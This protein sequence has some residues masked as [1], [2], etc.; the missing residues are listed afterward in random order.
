MIA[1]SDR[2]WRHKNK[3]EMAGVFDRIRS[4]G[5]LMS[6][7][8]GDDQPIKI[9]GPVNW[10]PNK[11]ALYHLF[12]EGKIMI[13]RRKG[14]QKVYDLPERW[15]PETVDIK[16]PTRREYLEFLVLRDL[17]THGLMRASEIGYL[18]KGL[19]Q[20]IRELLN[21]L[22]Q[23]GR[24]ISVK[25]HGT[26]DLPYYLFPET[27]ELL[28]VKG[29]RKWIRLLSPFDNLIINRKRTYEL[30]G[31]DYTLECYVPQKQRKFGYFGLP[32][33]WGDELIGQVD[34]KA[35]RKKKAL[36]VRNMELQSGFRKNDQVSSLFN[37]EL[38]RLMIFNRCENV[39][40]I[41]N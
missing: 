27:L 8:F 5:E 34:L 11:W 30:F 37:K 15:P 13:V 22:E 23:D 10:G 1:K 17:R 16:T 36:I 7:E 12:M 33:L 6:R 38:E 4:E 3:K 39:S 28:N 26:N 19:K 35:Y 25:I 9:K 21:K 14:F 18:L 29:Y 32:I 24:V 40:T 41:V 31:F 20:E 2:F